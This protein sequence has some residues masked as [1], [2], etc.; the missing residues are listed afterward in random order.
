MSKIKR[1]LLHF[2]T[3]GADVVGDF[4]AARRRKVK[5]LRR[6]IHICF[7]A[8]CALALGCIVTAVVGMNAA[9]IA[10]VVGALLSCG[11]AFFSL[12]GGERE[13]MVLYLLDLVYAVICAI[14]G[15]IAESAPLFVCSGLMLLAAATSIC[16][17]S[18]AHYRGFLENFDPETLTEDNYTVIGRQF[19]TAPQPEP[20]AEPILPPKSEMRVLAEQ[21][22]EILRR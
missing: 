8:H 16:G 1:R 20:P 6:I 2:Y 21:F 19:L 14:S 9:G 12:G 4:N 13:K 22:A 17:F 10:V 7:Y 3:N 18:A 11:V 5:S 15:G